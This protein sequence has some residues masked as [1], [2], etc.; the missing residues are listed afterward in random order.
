METANCKLLPIPFKDG[1]LDF[2]FLENICKEYGNDI[3]CFY[4][5][6]SHHNPLGI[7]YSIDDKIKLIRLCHQYKLHLIAD[8]VYNL[9][10]FDANTMMIPFIPCI[11]QSLYKKTE[12]ENE[13]KEV[14]YFCHSVSSFSK[15]I[16]PGWRI[17][18]IYTANQNL[19]KL[20]GN[21]GS[22]KSGGCMNQ[23]VP[24]LFTYLLDQEH[25][26]GD[27]D[28]TNHLIKVRNQLATNCK[29]LCGTIRKYD[30]QNIVKFNHPKG[31]YFLWM[32]LPM[33]KI[34]VLSGAEAN[35]KYFKGIK[36]SSTFGPVSQNIQFVENAQKQDRKR[37]F[38]QC[39]RFC[40]AY[41]SEEQIKEGAKCFVKLITDK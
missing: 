20:I 10:S 11:E 5:I 3:V 18:W 38:E 39:I 32:E 35:V 1:R 21:H 17:G 36:L 27:K 15:I 24:S 41:L 25:D 29:A 2:D 13:E 31:G 16:G 23:F 9:L 37:Y 7:S 4:V 6:P 8:E 22:I 14:E 12:N 19:L 33:D 34:K 30:T 26:D 28:M 40:F